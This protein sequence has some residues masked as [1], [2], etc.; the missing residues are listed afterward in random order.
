MCDSAGERNGKG[1][2]FLSHRCTVG[3]ITI[4]R[5]VI[6]DCYIPIIGNHNGSMSIRQGNQAD[7]ERTVWLQLQLHR[8]RWWRRRSRYSVLNSYSIYSIII[9]M[10]AHTYYISRLLQEKG[11]FLQKIFTLFCHCTTTQK[12]VVKPAVLVFLGMAFSL[13]VQFGIS[14]FLDL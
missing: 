11:L 10:L 13:V 8:S 1:V 9:I 2:R 6:C 5:Y 14:F 12:I 7:Q 3:D 4:C